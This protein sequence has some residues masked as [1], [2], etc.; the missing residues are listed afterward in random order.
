VT[1]LSAILFSVLI[2][3]KIDNTIFKLCAATLIAV[4][5]MTQFQNLLWVPL[6][7]LTF[8]GVADEKGNDYTAGH[9]TSKLLKIFFSYRFSMKVGLLVLCALSVIP[10]LYLLALLA[11]DGAYEAVRIISKTA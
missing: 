2:A 11:H 6:I 1:V 3:G 8:M 5:V 10:W 9:S 7:F 4:L